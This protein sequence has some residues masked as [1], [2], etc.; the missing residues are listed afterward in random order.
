MIHSFRQHNRNVPCYHV[1]SVN[2]E[3]GEFKSFNYDIINYSGKQYL[4][5]FSEYETCTFEMGYKKPNDFI[6][7]AK[8]LNYKK[9]DITEL[10]QYPVW[11]PDSMHNSNPKF[12]LED[13]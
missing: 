2:T 7:R 3:T 1:T 10:D 13:Q 11:N 6:K 4:L 12:E 8:E 9:F 5:K